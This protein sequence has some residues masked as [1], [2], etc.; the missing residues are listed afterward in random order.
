MNPAAQK[1]FGCANNEMV[2][3]NFVKLVPKSYGSDPN[4]QPVACEWLQMAQRTGSSTLAVGQN[5]KNVTFPIEISLSE[6]M[7]D[8][9]KLYAAMVRDVTE[10]KRFEQEIAAEKESL[11]VTLRSIGDGVITTDVQGK[12]VMINNAGETLTGWSSREAIGQPLKAVFNIAID[13]ADFQNYCTRIQRHIDPFKLL[14]RDNPY[15]EI[16]YSSLVK[17][18]E[19][20][21]SAIHSFLGLPNQ[22]TSPRLTKQLSRRREEVIVNWDETA[23][24]IKSNDNLCVIH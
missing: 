19:K 23:S 4:A 7:V 1:M 6:I 2:G 3:H 9:Q 21:M 16:H 17:D 24:F 22:E 18:R 8:R 10:R 11:A 5:R 15:L 12:V 14:F 20:T 13:L